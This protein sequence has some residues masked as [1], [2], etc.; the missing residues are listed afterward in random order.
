MYLYTQRQA[1]ACLPHF[2]ATHELHAVHPG[3]E[4]VN[5]AIEFV[6]G[7]HI[8]NNFSQVTPENCPVLRCLLCALQEEESEPLCHGNLEHA[9]RGEAKAQNLVER[10]GRDSDTPTAMGKW[11]A[12]N[13]L[14][15]RAYGLT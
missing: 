6:E 13:Q 12:R 3:R 14:R 4:R 10:G 9:P 8:G 5:E 1:S 7:R 2:I 15:L 11:L